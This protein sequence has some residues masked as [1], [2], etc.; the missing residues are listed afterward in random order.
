M[1]A[2]QNP[3]T[4]QFGPV[5]IIGVVPDQPREWSLRETS[6]L[7]AGSETTP[8]T[9]FW[10]YFGNYATVSYVPN[11]FLLMIFAYGAI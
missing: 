8:H 2:L 10:A 9:D 3:K 5:P 1:R 6:V 7:K 11:M 4:A